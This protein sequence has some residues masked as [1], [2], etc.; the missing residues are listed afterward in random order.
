VP[1]REATKNGFGSPAARMM[2]SERISATMH[3]LI[4]LALGGS[5]SRVP[6]F[7]DRKSGFVA[8][9]EILLH[10]MTK[11]FSRKVTSVEEPLKGLG[12]HHTAL[13]VLPELG[14]SRI[15]RRTRV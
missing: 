11:F 12:A 5:F 10:M 7:L 14:L 13:G 3:R 15:F 1:V 2:A 8:T 9:M 6:V 4:P